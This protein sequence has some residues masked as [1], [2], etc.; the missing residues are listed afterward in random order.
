V[1]PKIELHVH[2]EGSIRPATL[3]E[4][5]RRN[6]EKLPADSVEA[7]AKLYEFTDFAHFIDVWILTT[8]CLRTR[9]DF[10]QVALE[11]AA[12]AG[13]F[14]AVYVEGIFSP[15]E[16]VARG[17]DWDEIFGGYTDAV[18]EAEER[19]GVTLRFTPDLYRGVDVDVAEQAARTAVRY[20]DRGIVGLGLG[21]MEAG[22]AAEPYRRAFEIARDGGL[23]IVPHSGEAAGADS[24]R[25]ILAMDP[26]RIRHGIRAVDD[27][28][29]LAEIA[30]RGLVL[31]VCPTSNVRTG[32][33]P[34]L[35]EH[36]LPA[37]RAAGVHCTIN[38]DDPAMF[39][40]DLSRE[41]EVAAELGVSAAD[42]FAAGLAGALCDDV[43]RAR[44]A[45][46]AP[47]T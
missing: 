5:A 15:C 21:G 36:P 30:D 23:G 12:E 14:G 3:L 37:L 28:E 29:L 24:M 40:T 7:L 13:A 25:E 45:S 17:V 9:E 4:I 42:A 33:V 47:S 8:N 16:R 19:F 11:Y 35:A 10:R 32:C 26:D 27:P 22:L 39:G 43:T 31:D 2:L 38:T 44:L 20:R 34:S 46:L 1:I 18:A 6:Q 41:Y